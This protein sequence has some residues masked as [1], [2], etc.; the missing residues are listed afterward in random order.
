M[1]RRYQ[2]DNF[3]LH[4]TIIIQITNYKSNYQIPDYKSNQIKS[5]QMLVF[6]RGEKRST[7]RKTS[8]SRKE[9]QQTQPTYDAESGN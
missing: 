4:I 2:Y 5:N 3:H 7:R 8:R 6:G 9:N 1:L